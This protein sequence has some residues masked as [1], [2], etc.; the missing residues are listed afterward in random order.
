MLKSYTI[1]VD[2]AEECARIIIDKIKENDNQQF[3]AL[4]ESIQK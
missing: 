1:D 2:E 3:D 4:L